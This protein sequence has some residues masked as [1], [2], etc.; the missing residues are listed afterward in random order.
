MPAGDDLDGQS[1]NPAAVRLAAMNLL[2]RREHSQAELRQKLLRRFP[3][4]AVIAAVLAS[5]FA[6]RLQC[7][8]RYAQSLVRQRLNRG[9][10]PVRIRQA[11]RQLGVPADDAD[12]A[13]NAA[14]PDW[15]AL[16][17]DVHAQTER[18]KRRKLYLQTLFLL[19]CG[20]LA[21]RFMTPQQHKQMDAKN[22]P[23]WGGLS[24]LNVEAIWKGV[25]GNT[26]VL[27]YLRAVSTGPVAPIVVAPA[28]VG[29]GLHIGVT[30]R[31]S[32]FLR[33]DIERINERFMTCARRLAA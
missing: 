1:V 16:A 30:F 27:H 4:D 17:R 9:H 25:P 19:A 33:E 13:L 8:A 5:L 3:D 18:V 24:A 20:G 15:Q 6:E 28:S 14:E 29:D 12:A 22:H 32:A 7:D 21:W 10:G 31:T 26:P 23:V 2:A 11:L